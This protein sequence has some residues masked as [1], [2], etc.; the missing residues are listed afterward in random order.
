MR[1]RL[2]LSLTLVAVV[3]MLAACVNKGQQQPQ[4]QQSQ[5]RQSGSN[6]NESTAATPDDGV[7]RISVEEARAA[8]AQDRAVILDVRGTVEYELGHIKGARL[9]PLGEI[10][11]RAGELP[12]EKLIVT[13]C[14][15]KHEG[16]SGHAVQELQKQGIENA[17]ALT[18]GLDA[19]TAAGLPTESSNNNR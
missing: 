11:R 6:A 16:L 8:L 15:C 4:L 5:A 10:A 12:R 18:G 2:S 17:S 14:A 13:Y 3:I 9:L 1:R 7:R 19:W